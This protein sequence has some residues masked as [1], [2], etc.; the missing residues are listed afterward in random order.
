MVA[1]KPSDT[2]IKSLACSEPKL[3]SEAYKIVRQFQQTL[4]EHLIPKVRASP[5]FW[6]VKF[7]THLP[8]PWGAET[9]G[10]QNNVCC[11]VVVQSLLIG[12]P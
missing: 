4:F 7:P 10:T 8:M 6:E 2:K 12:M 9:V 5:P 1:E 3:A 11:L